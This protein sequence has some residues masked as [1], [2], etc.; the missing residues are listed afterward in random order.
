VVQQ[1]PKS[2]KAKEWEVMGLDAL[3]NAQ[4][5]MRSRRQYDDSLSEK[6][7]PFCFNYLRNPDAGSRS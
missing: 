3:I 5:Y 7:M 2:W 6:K 1:A 4:L